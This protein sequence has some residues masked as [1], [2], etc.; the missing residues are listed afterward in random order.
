M[1]RLV[2][3]A[4]AFLFKRQRDDGEADV[5][6]KPFI[7]W[8]VRNGKLLLDGRAYTYN[9]P[10]SFTELIASYRRLQAEL[11]GTDRWIE[12]VLIAPQIAAEL[13]GKGAI[14]YSSL[15]SADGRYGGLTFEMLL[16]D[17]RVTVSIKHHIRHGDFEFLVRGFPQGP[18]IMRDK[19]FI[20]A[21]L[22]AADGE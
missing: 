19:K 12:A 21:Q 10:S 8:Q 7:K 13:W 11:G 1:F 4:F 17:E 6:S 16:G 3:L 15:E 9:Q 5:I 2:R 22:G 14:E 20:L 18:L